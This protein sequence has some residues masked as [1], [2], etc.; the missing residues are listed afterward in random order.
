MLSTTARFCHLGLAPGELA[1]NV[2][3]VGDS[4]ARAA[5][6][7]ERFDEIVHDVRNREYVTLTGSYAG[8]PMSVI[9]TG[10]GVD[11][12]EI[13]LV[14]AYTTHAFDFDS[15]ERRPDA[16]PLKFMRIGTSAGVQDD[17]E[18]GT[19]AIATHGL[20]LDNGGMYYDHPAADDT[21]SKIEQ[22]AHEIL[23]NATPE[24]ARIQGQTASVCIESNSASCIRIGRQRYSAAG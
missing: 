3:L 4:G 7:Q 14:E 15:G 8:V 12:V 16:T 23:L 20:G 5:R 17:V 11:N 19:M 13:A 21:V 1:E 9:G 22:H 10:I 6:G 24:S 18:P 2:F